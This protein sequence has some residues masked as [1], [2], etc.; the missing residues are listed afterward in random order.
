LAEHSRY[1]LFQA[2]LIPVH[3]LRRNPQHP[4]APDW[5]IQ[6][7]TTLDVIDAMNDMNSS[8][9]KCRDVI[10]GLCGSSL[11]DQHSATGYGSGF[12][13]FESADDASTWP[14]RV[15]STIG[16]YNEWC[17]WLSQTNTATSAWAPTS[18]GD[19]DLGPIL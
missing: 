8:S 4:L 1:F 11:H 15:E 18:V 6:V 10:L 2:S 17:D 19:W 13:E 7:Q 5:R 12:T 9:S 14:G 16:G 3:C